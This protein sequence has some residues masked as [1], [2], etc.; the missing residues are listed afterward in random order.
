MDEVDLKNEDVA[1]LR[2]TNNVDDIA[3]WELGNVCTYKCSYCSPVFH[4]GDVPYQDTQLIQNTLNRLPPMQ[5]LF[6]GGEPTFHPDFEKIVNER[7]AHIKIGMVSNASRP[8]AFWERIID[9]MNFAILT[10]H[11]EY[12]NFD[13]FF[14]VAELVYLKN[15]KSGRVNLIMLPAQWDECVD[16]Y[17]KLSAAGVPVIAKQVLASFGKGC[18]GSIPD[19]TQ[20]QIDWLSSAAFPPS[21]GNVRISVFDK[22]HQVI[23][24]TS[25]N[26]LLAKNQTN[27]KGWTCHVPSQYLLITQGGFV[28]NT[29]CEQKKMVGTLKEGFTYPNPPMICKQNLCWCFTDIA[30]KK[31]APGFT[32]EIPK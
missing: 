8:Y 16:V 18:S 29:T 28:F 14:K 32:G 25:A 1:Y 20:E 4:A 19:Y 22:D 7:P 30:G 11:P 15:K 6:S 17:N 13:R 12:A 31:T 26:E 5:I 27:F 10:Y 24:L 2:Y 21:T 23:Y 3:Y 9:N